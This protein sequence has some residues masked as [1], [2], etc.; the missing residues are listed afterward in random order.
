MSCT[1]CNQTN[2]C[3]Q[4]DCTCRLKTSTDCATY[5]GDDLACSG[6]PK[7]TILTEALQM[8]DTFICTKFNSVVGYFSIINVGNGNDIYAG[9]NNLGQKKLKSLISTSDILDISSTDDEIQFS[10]DETE[11]INFITVNQF[12]YVVT[13][14]GGG[15]QVYKNTTGTNPKSFNL[16]TFTSSNGT[17]IIAEGT[18]TIDLAAIPNIEAGDNI[19][20]S[21]VGT[22][23]DPIIISSESFVQ[24]GDNISVTGTGTELDPFIIEA[25]LPTIDI[26]WFTGDTKEVVCDS[27]YLA[28]NFDGTGLGTNERVGW[29]IMNGNNGT[30]NDNGRT[31]IAYGSSYTT[32]EAVGG[33]K[34]AV[35][36]QHTHSLRTYGNGQEGNFPGYPATADTNGLIGDDS[37]A[38]ENTGV[39]GTDKNMQ[40]YTVRLRIMKL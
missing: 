13:N 16:K 30:P 8:M 32:L 1:N 34:D 4:V 22:P 40:P 36:V 12:S 38:V 11:L 21:G 19:T 17:V 23:L 33:S 31:V 29:A 15:A 10:V 37:V 24:A 39:S 26:S 14:L 7:G 25:I 18:N 6:I 2:P 3:E 20:L 27:I 35:V 28:A 9:D 5:T